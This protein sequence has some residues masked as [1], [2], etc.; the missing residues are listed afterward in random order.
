MG[1]GHK[2]SSGTIFDVARATA[3][4]VTAMGGGHKKRDAPGGVFKECAIVIQGA[5][6]ESL[7]CAG[8]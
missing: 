8:L 4:R 6:T 5:T 1:G 7:R 3:R 2:K